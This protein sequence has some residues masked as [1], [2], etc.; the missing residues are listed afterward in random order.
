MFCPG[1]RP[2][3]PAPGTPREAFD[4]ITPEQALKHPTWNMGG[5]I[6]ID[7]ATMFNK[8]LEIVEAKWLFGLEPSQI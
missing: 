5:K 8:A 4:A 2:Q 6:T 3:G 7:S 1:G